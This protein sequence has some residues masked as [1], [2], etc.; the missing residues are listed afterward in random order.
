M[1][2]SKEIR[3]LLDKQQLHDLVLRYARAIDRRDKT[4]LLSLYHDGA[5]DDHGTV[6]KGE[7]ATFSEAQSELMK[8]FQVTAHYITNCLFEIEGDT[9]EGEIYFI[10]YHRTNHQNPEEVIVGGRYLDHYIR[11]DKT[12][13]IAHR[14][15]VWD[16]Y[17]TIRVDDTDLE[18]LRGLG[19]T[20]EGA[21]DIS[22]EHLPLLSR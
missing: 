6:F 2:D 20:G 22:I 4:M 17:R 19:V 21:N 15:L 11:T 14:V 9:A 13:K 7:A 8:A 5:I 3:T 12:W 10:A 16:S 18:N 1:T